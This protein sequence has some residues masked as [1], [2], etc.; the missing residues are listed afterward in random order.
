MGRGLQMGFRETIRIDEYSDVSWVCSDV[1]NYIH[2][3]RFCDNFVYSPEI[4]LYDLLYWANAISQDSHN[5]IVHR[6][7]KIEQD[8]E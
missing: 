3:I 7:V 8:C 2:L 5:Y 4:F 6:K 1:G